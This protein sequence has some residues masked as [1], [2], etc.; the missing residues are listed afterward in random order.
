MPHQK[1]TPQHWRTSIAHHRR[2]IQP[3]IIQ[4]LPRI[5]ISIISIVN[6]CQPCIV[7]HR[8]TSTTIVIHRYP[9]ST[10]VSHRHP[11]TAIVT[12]V[13]HRHQSPTIVNHRHPSLSVNHRHPSIVKHRHPSTLYASR[14][15]PSPFPFPCSTLSMP[16]QGG[17][18]QRHAFSSTRRPE[19][20]DSVSA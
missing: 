10:I 11:S 2:I 4:P 3:L 18:T 13:N 12:V 5:T 9:P 1:S 14:Q 19:N 6:H 20:K 8:H 7:K 16:R 17:Y 15:I